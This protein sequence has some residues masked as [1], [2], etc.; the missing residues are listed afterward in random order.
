VNRIA[1]WH[2]PRKLTVRPVNSA[3]R[4]SWPAADSNL[5]LETASVLPSSN[6][7][8]V[9]EIPASLNA[10]LMVTNAVGTTNQFYRLRQQQNGG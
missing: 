5:V 6:W 7:A 2:F 3:L 8:V 10:R 9:P 4:I 1:S